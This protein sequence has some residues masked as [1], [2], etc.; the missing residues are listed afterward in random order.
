MNLVI[1]QRKSVISSS[2]LSVS[3]LSSDP[4]WQHQNNFPLPYMLIWCKILDQWFSF[5]G[6]FLHCGNKC[7]WNSWKFLIFQCNCDWIIIFGYLLSFFRPHR[8]EKKPMY[9]I[10]WFKACTWIIYWEES[11]CLV[12]EKKNSL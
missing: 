12:V 3:T 8:F 11:R 4:S 5:F 1:L 6:E 10:L 7:L 2:A 9:L